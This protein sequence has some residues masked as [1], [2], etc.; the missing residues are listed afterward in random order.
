M[1]LDK[2]KK[3]LGLQITQ[4]VVSN[5]IW[6]LLFSLIYWEM[7]LTKWWL[8]QSVWGRLIIVLSEYALFNSSFQKEK[9]G[10]S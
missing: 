2:E 7:D 8:T 9:D 1:S 6:Y 4:F 10:K 5:I 3:P